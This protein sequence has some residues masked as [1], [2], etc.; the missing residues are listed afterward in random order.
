MN[1]LIF[2]NISDSGKESL[3][4][5]AIILNPSLDSEGNRSSRRGS[6]PNFV[7]Y[8]C[9]RESKGVDLDSVPQGNDSLHKSVLLVDD[10]I[11]IYSNLGK[12]IHYNKKRLYFVLEY[13]ILERARDIA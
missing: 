2:N 10:L 3:H 1:S 8:N 12:Y 9:L 4:G 11:F 7:G 5:E 6:V 13:C